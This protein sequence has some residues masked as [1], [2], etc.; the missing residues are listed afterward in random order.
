MKCSETI[1][2]ELTGYWDITAWIKY[3]V[4]VKKNTNK[5][6]AEKVQWSETQ[7]WNLK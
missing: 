5:R 2:E 3:D 6:R 1:K 7:K 4:K